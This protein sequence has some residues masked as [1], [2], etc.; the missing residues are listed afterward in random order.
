MV[1]KS[2]SAPSIFE[3]NANP[4][5]ERWNTWLRSLLFDQLGNASRPKLLFGVA[6][7]DVIAVVVAWPLAKLLLRESSGP[8][9]TSFFATFAVAL[10]TITVLR[11]QWSYTIPALRKFGPQ[12]LKV[13]IAIAAIAF[14]VSGV[15]FLFD[16]DAASAREIAVWME[17]SALLLCCVRFMAAEVVQRLTRAGSLVR[18]TV[19]V[20]GGKDAEDLIREFQNDSETHLRILGIFDDRRRERTDVDFGGIARLGTFEDLSDFCRRSGVDLLIVTVPARA[21]ERLMQILTKL[22]T[23]PVDVRVSAL[24]S[25][26]RLSSRAYNFI[27]RVPML[28]VMDKPLSDWDRVLKNI[29]D[30]VIGALLL[31]LASPVMALI[32]IAVHLDS[33]GPILFRQKRYGFN[34]ELIEVLKF[35][36]LYVDKQDATGSKVVTRHDPRVTRVGAF[37]RRTSLD[38]LP[39]LIN[40]VKGEMS[41]VGPRPHATGSRAERDL[42]ENV[43]QDYFARHRMKPGV[44]GWAQINGWRGET[45]TRE[46]L[47]Q[48]VEHDLYYIDHWSVLLDLYII[49][50]TPFSLISGKNAY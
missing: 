34:N 42:F 14:G 27:G 37:I 5:S 19:I 33:K 16:D 1:E 23:L 25:K 45:D 15:L 41:L 18:R 32:A 2:G 7:A 6:L 47:V 17:L 35:R 30:R 43:V 9:A 10:C 49:A 22:F 31:L 40:V 46:K 24:N 12:V 28:A 29:E 3:E 44:T 48:R 4:R 26:L 11:W 8:T 21:E 50:M 20:G 36:S 13:F 38:E 39:Q